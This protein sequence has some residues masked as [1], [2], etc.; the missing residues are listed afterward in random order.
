MKRLSLC[1]LLLCASCVGRGDASIVLQGIGD[2]ALRGLVGVRASLTVTAE[3]G[4]HPAL[5]FSE[6]SNEGVVAVDVPLLCDEVSCGGAINIDP[7]AYAIE[8]VVSAV[9]RCGTRGDVL[10]FEGDV[11]IGHWQSTAVNLAATD[12]SFDDDRDGIINVLEAASCGRFDLDEGYSAA[13]ECSGERAAEC[14]APSSLLIGQMQRFNGGTVSLPYDRDGVAGRDQQLVPQFDIDSTEFTYGALSRCVAAGVCLP[15]QPEHPARVRLAQGVDF[16]LPVQGLMPAD[17]E[18]ACGFYGR[19]L[20]RDAEWHFVAADRG[21][22]NAPG[23]FPFD[24]EPGQGVGC[25]PDDVPPAAAHRANNRACGDGAPLP[26]GS[27]PSTVITRG[28]GPGV[29]DLAGNVAEWTVLDGAIGLRGG[30]ASSIVQLLENDI[31][32]VF[33]DDDSA[34]LA[35]LQAASAVAGFRCATSTRDIDFSEEPACPTQID[36]L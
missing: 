9:D 22:G 28:D 30:G 23:V 25:T 19:R 29:V 2:V 15:N 24:V 16:L 12:A 27:F 35:R 6:V 7:G 18:I 13:R 10:R 3:D 1:T 34:D 5:V 17:A 36:E 21:V 4:S 31:V 32:L 11:E 26:V 33:D 8:L 14:C 20:V